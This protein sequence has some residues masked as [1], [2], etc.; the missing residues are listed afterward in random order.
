MNVTRLS[1]TA[2]ACLLCM[3]FSACFARF[4]QAQQLIVN[5]GFETGN[6]SGWTTADQVSPYG[7]GFA[8]SNDI[9]SPINGLPTV[10]PASGAYYAVSDQTGPGAHVMY[11]SFTVPSGANIL[12]SFDLFVN[13]WFDETVIDPSG[14]DWTTGGTLDPNQH[15]RVDLLSGGVDPFDTGAGVA[16]NFYIGADGPDL[17]NR[18]RRYTFFVPTYPFGG[19][20]LLR[21]AEVDNQFLLNAGVDNVSVLVV[22]EPGV[23]ALAG[24]LAAGTVAVL[25]GRWRRA[26]ARRPQPP[27]TRL[28]ASR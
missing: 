4:A 16:R 2:L 15:A 13:N 14:L 26:R 3:L 18:Y 7:G 9:A 27:N 11:Q 19:T 21:F 1:R 8:E 28:I 12:V 17:P 10:G 22:P 20:F 5:G 6:L 25:L 23:G 24:V